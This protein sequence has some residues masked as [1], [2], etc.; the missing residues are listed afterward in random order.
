M[1][2]GIAKVFSDNPAQRPTVKVLEYRAKHWIS[3]SDYRHLQAIQISKVRMTMV[4]P[5][6]KQQL[7]ESSSKAISKYGF[8]KVTI[9]VPEEARKILSPGFHSRDEAT[10]RRIWANHHWARCWRRCFSA[11]VARRCFAFRLS[12]I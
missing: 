4:L 7:I 6:G 3:K 8:E 5:D 9:D 12:S 2:K 1:T 10:T 11:A